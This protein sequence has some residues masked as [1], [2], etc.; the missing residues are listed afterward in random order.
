MD[1]V[2]ASASP[3][4]VELLRAAGFQPLVVPADLDETGLPGEAPA[5]HVGRLARAK[6]HSIAARFP[7]AAVLAA[8]TVVALDD[9]ILGKPRDDDDA[10]RMLGRLAGRAHRVYT[11]V[12]LAV[13]ADMRVEVAVSEVTMASLSPAEVE[14][15]LASGEG[16]DKAGAY[17]IQ[18]LASRYVT[19]IQGSYSNVVGLPVAVVYRWLRELPVIHSQH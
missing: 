12:A 19:G 16:R 1:L 15:Y 4:R 18:G 7:A 6:A 2:L 3:R 5:A 8:D 17:A 13:G 10:R 11:G 9:E 14:W